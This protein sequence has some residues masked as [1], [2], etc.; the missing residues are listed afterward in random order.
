MI[1]FVMALIVMV[2]IFALLFWEF[3]PDRSEANFLKHQEEYLEQEGQLEQD[4]HQDEQPAKDVDSPVSCLPEHL[5][6]KVERIKIGDKWM[7]VVDVQYLQI[8]SNT[9][10]KIEL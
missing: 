3:T 1:G 9:S 7:D 10:L 5:I 6:E 2:F 4:E 8:E